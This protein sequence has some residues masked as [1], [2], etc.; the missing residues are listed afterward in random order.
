MTTQ[1]RDRCATRWLIDGLWNGSHLGDL[2]IDAWLTGGMNEAD[3][4]NPTTEVA[5]G[6]STDTRIMMNTNTVR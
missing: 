5:S 6:K 1:G 4:V 3:A 2:R